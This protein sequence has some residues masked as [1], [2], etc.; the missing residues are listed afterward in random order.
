MMPMRTTHPNVPPH[1]MA[2]I[3]AISALFLN[4]SNV[5]SF[6]VVDDH[7]DDDD[8]DDDDKDDDKVVWMS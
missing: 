7:D 8:D 5:P 4:L 1:A 6:D 2:I 3:V